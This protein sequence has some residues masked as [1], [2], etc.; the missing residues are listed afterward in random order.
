MLQLT[1]LPNSNTINYHIILLQTFYM[2]IN[3]LLDE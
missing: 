2:A 1:L 3:L